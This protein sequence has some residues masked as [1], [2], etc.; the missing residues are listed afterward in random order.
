MSR[1]LRLIPLCQLKPSK[2][3]VRK[4][5][6]LADIESMAAN[7]DANDLLENLLVKALPQNNGHDPMFEVVAGGRRFA[8]LKL[9]AKR[10]KIARDHAI[11]CLVLN[12]DD[13]TTELSLAENLL[14]APLHPADQ[15]EAFAA[16]VHDG[17]PIDE[18]ASRFAVTPTFV[19]QRL[20]LAS[21]SPRLVAEYRAGA[22]SLEQLTAFT[23]SADHS[24][25]EEVWFDR[26]YTDI[27]ASA[28]RRMLTSAQ[29]QGD[30]R[31]A[32]FIGAKAYE[33]AGGIIVRDLFDSEDEGYFG[34]SQ[35][36]DRMVA[37]KLEDVANSVRAEGW[38]W[39]EVHPDLDLL[40]VS[41]FGKAEISVQ[42]ISE[43]E[44][45]RLESLGERYDELV[46][47]LEDGDETLATEI[48]RVAA[49]IGEIE[50][51]KSS[52]PEEEKARAGA[53]V[54]LGSDGH[55]EIVRGL[56]KPG[57]VSGSAPANEPDESRTNGY[58]DSVVRD[59]AAHR[60]AA[61]REMLAEQ[62]SVASVALLHAVVG[63]L[64][65]R[66]SN[67]DALRII[68]SA[69]DPENASPSLGESAAG[70]AFAVRHAA[71]AARIPEADEL[72]NWLVALPV[73]D[74]DKLLA[75]CVG[76]TVDALHEGRHNGPP[77]EDVD[78]LAAALGLEMCT[79]WRPTQANFLGRITKD[80][81]LS[82]V[83]EGVSQQAAWRLAKLKKDGM[84]KQAE[85]LLA[86]SR[87]LPQPLRLA[88]AQ[89]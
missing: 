39:V 60:T 47:A 70:Q 86:E 87:W 7:I 66:G 77:H 45:A 9:L 27:P 37:E 71:W 33:A 29:V 63:Q 67:S 28:I 23:L 85:K 41:R 4:T 6:R 79:W 51:S 84:A 48:D 21:V 72:W 22:M 42:P 53:I 15:F 35:L 2:A 76:M 73:E 34:D 64:F 57:V 17:L 78:R 40:Q 68:A 16:L 14:R 54:S 8:A 81:I 11:R 24:V 3:N 83:S 31:R 89:Q 80:E 1:K 10:K 43:E 59:L 50:A 69:V 20:K 58:S 38:S 25:Q 36:L 32:R 46:A 49:E 44:E 74:R 62:P 88:A 55:P 26:G 18:I 61:L 5:D 30:D 19:E 52:W 12:K 75:H 82:A 56:L 13:S 65:Y